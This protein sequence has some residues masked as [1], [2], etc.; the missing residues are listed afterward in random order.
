MQ[1]GKNTRDPARDIDRTVRGGA[2]IQGIGDEASLTEA[3]RSAEEVM[4]AALEA[5][6][7]SNSMEDLC[8]L[9]SEMMDS[10]YAHAYSLYQ[11]NQLDQ[12]ESFF[13]FLCIYDFHNID[14]SL[15]LGAVYQLKK[16]YRKAIEIYSAAYIIGNNDLRP[17]FH[18]GQCCLI[19]EDTERARQCFE[20]VLSDSLDPALQANASAYIKL[21]TT[22]TPRPDEAKHD[23]L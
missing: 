3:S 7:S 19:S 15:G 4:E 20:L 22:P 13:R 10:L 16:D 2:P 21:L 5:A 8:G 9:S 14:Y 12:A 6:L 11:S 18:A 23:P 1:S 17:V